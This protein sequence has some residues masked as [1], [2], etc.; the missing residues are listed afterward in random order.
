[1]AGLFDKDLR[2]L[3]QRK[4]AIILFLAI[5]VIIGVIVQGFIYL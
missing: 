4:Q 5:A 1:M 3:L 2:I